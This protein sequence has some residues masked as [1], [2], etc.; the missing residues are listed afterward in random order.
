VALAALALTTD[1]AFAGQKE[2]AAMAPGSEAAQAAAPGVAEPS[3]SATHK[4]C[5]SMGMTWDSKLPPMVNATTG[6]ITVGCHGGV[7]SMPNG[8]AV[9]GDCGAY[10]GDTICSKPLPLLCINKN[11]PSSYPKP[12]SVV[13]TPYY[14]WTP[15]VVGTTKDVIP[16]REAQTIGAA[17]KIC[18]AE[19]GPGWR[20]AE[21]HDGGTGYPGWDLQA[22]GNVGDHTRRFWVDINDQPNGTCWTR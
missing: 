15:G 3:A 2:G 13:T 10:S 22:Y 1:G 6:T 17:N 16:C 11:N 14:Q 12:A 18:E 20:V 4:T 5:Q 7:S 19:F 9:N 8:V 21:D